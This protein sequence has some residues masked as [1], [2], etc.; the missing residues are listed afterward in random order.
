M[1]WIKQRKLLPFRNLYRFALPKP[2][3]EVV[4]ACH[5][6]RFTRLMQ[7][8]AERCAVRVHATSLVARVLRPIRSLQRRFEVVASAAHLV[9]GP[10]PSAEH[11]V[12]L[13]I[14]HCGTEIVS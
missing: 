14:R 5:L 9:P 3:Y 6:L 8:H 4:K 2:V 12:L 7:M 11:P 13:R 10:T 1:N